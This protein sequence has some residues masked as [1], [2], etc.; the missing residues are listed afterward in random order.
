MRAQYKELCNHGV[1]SITTQRRKC[2]YRCHL[3]KFKAAINS[4]FYYSQIL[5]LQHN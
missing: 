1:S 2:E 3:K 5:T 4:N